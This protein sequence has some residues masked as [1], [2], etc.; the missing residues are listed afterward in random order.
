MI[1]IA[2]PI[3][4]AIASLST[5]AVAAP[6]PVE[7]H[8][9]IS[10]LDLSTNKG[11]TKLQARLWSAIRE[12][13]APQRTAGIRGQS[14]FRSCVAEKTADANEDRDEILASVAANARVATL[15]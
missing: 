1:K 4:F 2:L 3:A 12:A 5:N 7:I 9:S 15:R 13:C 14:K 6:Q 11:R 10:D 8:V